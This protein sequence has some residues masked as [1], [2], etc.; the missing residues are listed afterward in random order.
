MRYDHFGLANARE[1]RAF[2]LG[3]QTAER[4]RREGATKVSVSH[5]MPVLDQPTVVVIVFAEGLDGEHTA[6]FPRQ[7]VRK[8]TALEA[9]GLG[10]GPTVS[11][12]PPVPPKPGL[13]MVEFA[14][15]LLRGPIPGT[16][17]GGRA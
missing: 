9:L 5:G 13:D 3:V 15:T 16:P 2:R 12:A 8:P 11:F 10:S 17:T 7:P 1:A 14:N 4:L 6:G